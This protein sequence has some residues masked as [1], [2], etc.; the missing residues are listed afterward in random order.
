MPPTLPSVAFVVYDS[1]G[2]IVATHYFSA[3]DD[4]EI[5]GP[6]TLQAM[7]IEAA[8]RDSNIP[9]SALSAKQVD[10]KELRPKTAYRV[11]VDTGEITAD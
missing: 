11:A 7:A 4:A 3:A 2:E 1:S 6:D 10:P 9:A 8:S 5:P